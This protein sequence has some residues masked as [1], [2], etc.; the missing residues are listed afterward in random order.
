MNLNG[1]LGENFE[2]LMNSI[3]KGTILFAIVMLFCSMIL[4]GCGKKD[5]LIGTWKYPD[6]TIT[7]QFKDDG[8]VVISNQTTSQSL[9]Y[10]KEDPDI[11][12][13]QGSSDGSFPE[14][15]MNYR[16][17]EDRLILS[18]Q[19]NETVLTKEK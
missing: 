6:T 3:K 10:T 4:S 9:P 15:T 16:I 5:P 14:M 1:T 12:K 17:E 13:I 19:G 8:N 2:V 7:F 18:L 11:L